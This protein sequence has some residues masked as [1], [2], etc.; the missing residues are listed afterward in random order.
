[1]S[2]PS[3]SRLTK[4]LNNGNIWFPASCDDEPSWLLKTTEIKHFRFAVRQVSLLENGRISNISM[5]DGVNVREK[6]NW[7][8]LQT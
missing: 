2:E 4:S 8:S 7:S 5:A 3:S 1:M 6:F